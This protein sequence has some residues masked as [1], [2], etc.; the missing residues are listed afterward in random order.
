MGAAVTEFLSGLWAAYKARRAAK[1]LEDLAKGKAI[2]DQ[3]QA[4][5]DEMEKARKELDASLSS[6]PAV[7]P[8]IPKS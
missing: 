1:A 8:P 4:E 5:A 3:A 6:A 2:L 7:P